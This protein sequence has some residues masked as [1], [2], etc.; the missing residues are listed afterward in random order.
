VE[1]LLGCGNRRDKRIC[2]SGERLEWDELVTVDMDPA[3]APDIVHDLTH[4][5]WPIADNACS[6]VH[7]YDVLEHLGRQG[8]W[9]GFFDDF[10]EIHRILAPNGVLFATVPINAWIWGDPGHTRY[11]GP[12][13]LVFLDQSQYETQVGKSRMTDYRHYWKGDL[14]K[15]WEQTSEDAYAFALRCVK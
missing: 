12:E 9:R 2:P 1:L 3:C 6:Q 10:A 15:V 14:R 8:D 4:R 11:I 13:S 7:A 5:P